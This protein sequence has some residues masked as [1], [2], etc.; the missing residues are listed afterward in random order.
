VQ[1]RSGNT[2]TP[3]G[4]WSAWSSVSNGGTIASPAGRYLQYQVTLTTT[5][6]TV[7]PTLF[8]ISFTWA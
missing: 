6:P 3:D 5:D 2:A 8:S 4:S 7:T 1:T